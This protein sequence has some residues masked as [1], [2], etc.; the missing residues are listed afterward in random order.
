MM[1]FKRSTALSLVVLA[2]LVVACIV[3]F[4]KGHLEKRGPSAAAPA[5]AG[6]EALTAKLPLSEIKL[7]PGFKISVFAEVPGARSM[8]LSPSG[9]LYVGSGGLGG[10]NKK[11]YAVQDSNKDG[12]ADS[13]TV[14]LDGLDS[15]NG[16]AFKDGDLYVAEISRILKYKQVEKNLNTISEPEVFNDTFP[17]D[18]AHG[19]KFIRFAPD[20]SLLVPVGAP[21]NNCLREN[22]HAAIFKLSP[23]GKTKTMIAQG[24][25]NTVGFD[26]DP[27]TKDLVFTENGRDN[28]G[29][30]VPFCELNKL[31]AANWQSNKML[32]FGFPYC[33]SGNIADPQFGERKNCSE[34]VKPVMNFGAHV[35]P[36]GMRFYT[37]SAF[38]KEFK[39][40]IFAAEHGSWNRDEP[41]GYRVSLA[42]T[43]DSGKTYTYKIFAEGWLRANGE[44]WG[45]PV[46]I[47][48]LPDG[49][50]LVSD[51]YAG[52]I[53]RISY[54][55]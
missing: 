35:A 26:F 27:Q 23:D 20:G 44:K 29:N 41:Q 52:V 6:D 42:W 40:Q 50:I 45:R 48:N 15:P 30:D 13:V 47:E 2:T 21:C 36:L 3:V 22:T 10:E 28:L 9:I 37:G 18:L 31:P 11:V 32:H 51:D 19:W 55:P 12:K 33:H 8:A 53:Y 38:P 14:I 7:P 54:A 49:S 17:K 39:N 25:R 16:V 34:F 43:E 4:S 24:V 1:K 5:S 46:D